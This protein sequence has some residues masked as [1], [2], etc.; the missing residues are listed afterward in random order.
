MPEHQH[1]FV[2][3]LHRSG[4][5]PLA[6]VLGA[7]S[8]ISGLSGTGVPEDEG[9]HLQDVFPRIRAY[10]GMSRFA[11]ATDAHLTESSPLV[12][13]ENHKRL[14][15]TWSPYWD[16]SKPFLLEKS[17]ANMIRFR[18]LQEIFPGSY[19]IAIARHPV[20]TA[21]AIQKWNPRIVARNGRRRV[22]LSD[23]VEHWEVAHSILRED[24][25]HLRNVHFLCYEQLVANPDLELKKVQEFLGLR[26]P[27][28]SSA[29][30]GGFGSSYAQKWASMPAGGVF[31]R[32]QYR[33]I[34]GMSLPE[35]SA[36]GYSVN[37]LPA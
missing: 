6:R 21:L 34:I 29:I 28:D 24:V 3:G 20:V 7:H 2:G 37:D 11:R 17:P 9:E 1:I 15:E 31:S 18:F 32:R 14:M 30:R 36:L 23:T 35:A 13:V 26:T 27:I 4:T 19:F 25:P 12:S 33:K 8:E 5:T 16:L 22:S 10:G